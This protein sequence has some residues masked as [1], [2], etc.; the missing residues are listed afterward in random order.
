[1]QEFRNCQRYLTAAKRP[2]YFVDTR[3]SPGL[4]AALILLPFQSTDPKQRVNPRSR[5]PNNHKR[6]EHMSEDAPGFHWF[7]QSWMARDH[8]RVTGTCSYFGLELI[9]ALERDRQRFTQL[10]FLII[11]GSRTEVL[12]Q[13]RTQPRLEQPA[14]GYRPELSPGSPPV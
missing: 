7:N 11:S 6:T 13:A 9:R 4:E 12:S 2:G 3:F 8:E 5:L 10:H 1:M 14:L